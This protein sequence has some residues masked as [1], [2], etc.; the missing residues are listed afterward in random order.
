MNEPTDSAGLSRR[1]FFKGLGVT[2][3]AAAA[4]RT[5]AVARE[6]EKLNAER[7][8][9]PGTVPIALKINGKIE[10]FDLEPRVTLLDA[11]R[12][13]SHH[14]E[15]KEVCDRATC[16]ACTVLFDGT[17]IY[18]CMKLAIEAQGHEITTVA[19]ITSGEQLT[20]VQQEFINCDGLQCGYCTPGFVLSVTALLEHTP[21]PTEAEVRK[22]VSGH[23]C[24]CGSYPR[25]FEAALKAAGVETA[26]TCEIRRIQNV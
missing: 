25:I 13:V 26:S 4:E 8:Q 18:A 23:L 7:I 19:G 10:K 24:R 9:G 5:Q 14:T 11:L 1:N 21:K 16:G 6:M 15:A 17:P 20:K 3:V 22:A 12:N 2:A